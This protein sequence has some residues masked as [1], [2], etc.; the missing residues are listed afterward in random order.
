[1]KAAARKDGGAD[2]GKTEP[3]YDI[4]VVSFADESI[5]N[6]AQ[7]GPADKYDRIF[8]NSIGDV[9]LYSSIDG[10]AVYFDEKGGEKKALDSI[11]GPDFF[12][13]ANSDIVALSQ[14]ETSGEAVIKYMD[15]YGNI[16]K[17][18]EKDIV[19]KA[20][21]S[22]ITAAHVMGADAN[23]N[24]FMTYFDG[25][26]QKIALY[27]VTGDKICEFDFTAPQHGRYFE[28]SAAAG[29]NGTLYLG[30]P[31]EDN[32]YVVKIPYSSVVEYITKK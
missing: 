10:D 24:L 19:L 7:G 25:E 6:A 15:F 16:M 20:G 30:M 11:A 31:L 5:T 28:T 17:R 12:T 9:M 14:N 3:A 22:N 32:Y 1:I 29:A 13:L 8:A 21:K 2:A 23:T 26:A 18:F 4:K 27:S